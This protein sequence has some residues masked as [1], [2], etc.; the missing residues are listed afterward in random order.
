MDTT[1]TVIEMDSPEETSSIPRTEIIKS[2]DFK[3]I[4]AS[5][6]FGNLSNSEGQIIFFIDRPTP[7]MA[8]DNVMTSSHLQ[9]E[10]QMELHL[11]HD[12]FVSVYNWMGRHIEVLKK[13][14]EEKD[15]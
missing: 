10:L 12:T 4:Y 14:I 9:R 6:L 2:P 3:V 5:G 1:I 15:T 7:I 8:E 11:S 13:K